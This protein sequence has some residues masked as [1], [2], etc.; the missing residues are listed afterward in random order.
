MKFVTNTTFL[1]VL[2]WEKAAESRRNIS[3]QACFG[4][5]LQLVARELIIVKRK[6]RMKL[7]TND[8]SKQTSRCN[9][10]IIIPNMPQSH[11][12]TRKLCGRTQD[13]MADKDPRTETLFSGI[14]VN[15]NINTYL[16]ATCI[17]VLL[18]KHDK[19]F[20]TQVVPLLCQCFK[21]V[22]Q[23]VLRI[24]T[25]SYQDVSSVTPLQLYTYW[26]LY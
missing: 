18:T 19:H 11:S 22:I 15:W 6:E 2:C 17:W 10:R 24:T 26:L 9:H 7:N 5:V 20:L 1:A 3:T 4:I 25:M 12:T 21:S 16:V 13:S 14:K 8:F 23:S